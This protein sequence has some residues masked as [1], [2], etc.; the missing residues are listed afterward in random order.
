M[1]EDAS[2]EWSPLAPSSTA[3]AIGWKKNINKKKR[4]KSPKAENGRK[5]PLPPASGE[6]AT[7]KEQQ[8]S[9]SQP[10]SNLATEEKV[11]K[12]GPL[13]EG[14]NHL[15]EIQQ[16]K[17]SKEKSGDALLDGISVQWEGST[18]VLTFTRHP[19][20]VC[21]M[22]RAQVQVVSGKIEILGYHVLGSDEAIGI[23][24]P[25]WTSAITL[26][27]LEAQ[28]SVRVLSARQE[29][30]ERTFCLG[31][32]S[33]DD[34]RPT[35]IPESWK[36]AMDCV[37]QDVSS[38]EDKKQAR[39]VVCGAKHVGKS[40]CIRYAVHR[41]LS[42]SVKTVALL[43]CDM[44][45]PEMS[46]PGM[47]TLTL[48]DTPLLSPPHHHMVIGETSLVAKQHEDAYFY[49]H[50][51]S[52][53]DPSLFLQCISKLLQSYVLL[54][55]ERYGGDESQLPLLVNTDGWVKGMGFEVLT[56]TLDTICPNHVIQLM[57]QQVRSKMFDLTPEILKNGGTLHVA[58]SYRNSNATHISGTPSDA[59]I[60]SP[61][62]S[63]PS[64]FYRSLR[65]CTYFLGNTEIWDRV[66]FGQCGIADHE[67][68]IGRRLASQKPYAVPMDCVRYGTIRGV[69]NA[70]DL[71]SEDILLDALNGSIVGLC[72]SRTQQT[73]SSAA[74]VASESTFA[75]CCL[76]CVGLGL[77]RSI[78]R[79]K[80]YFYI[81]TP[82]PM[83]VL[84]NVDEIVGG[85]IQVPTE[86][87]YRG[88]NA[89]SFPYL[90]CDGVSIGIGGEF[91]KS[92]NTL[93]RRANSS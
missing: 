85:S 84:Q 5:R 7:T 68:E 1:G 11:P 43:D 19:L 13:N 71:G 27:P 76:P 73:G 40:T 3:A 9:Q 20:H 50:T 36:S 41:L 77:I 66:E 69:D 88:V 49:G 53:A 82:V 2:T 10:A 59:M 24:S 87:L 75:D 86:C 60:M 92:R 61:V 26:I 6:L 91:M 79:V 78:D 30:T 35:M 74:V 46:P 89:E 44:G 90:S 48:V 70:R 14:S 37:V 32:P 52:K 38:K 17:Q 93:M 16:V 54:V 57:G 64:I 23:E 31:D 45:Q 81:L 67:C 62:A 34:V 8:V 72:C 22:G 12:V 83:T 58:H 28:T 29:S 55:E 56:A 15:V 33:Q 42:H 51:T 4:T 25:T 39:V 65:L 21:V 80:R 47:L 18:A 63:I